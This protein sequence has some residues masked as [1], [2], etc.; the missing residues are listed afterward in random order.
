MTA[1]AIERPT[2][3][4][5]DAAAVLGIS[6]WTT[7]LQLYRRLAGEAAPAETDLE[8]L[9]EAV[10]WGNLLEPVVAERYAEVTGR[11]VRREPRRLRHKVHAMLTAHIDRR[12]DDPERI[13]EVKT[14]RYGRDWGAEGTDEVPPHYVA[15]CMHYLAVTGAKVCDLA[16]LI[17]G[18]D[19]RVYPIER[20][21]AVVSQLIERE[22]EFWDR[23]QRRDPP[24][25]LTNAEAAGR[26]LPVIGKTLV[27]SPT[28]LRD[29]DELHSVRAQIAELEQRQGML[30]LYLKTA[31][32]DAECLTD[33]AGNVHATWKGQ[34][35]RRLD[36]KAIRAAHEE[37]CEPFMR[38]TTTRVFRLTK[39]SP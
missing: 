22:L 9:S 13:L 5:S 38:E 34:S 15:Q 2:I 7:P 19:F 11:K 31:M 6:P 12:T 37:L 16:V 21:E 10:R 17:A 4:G 14:A 32:T 1:P 30:E 24:D 26:W 3:G 8:E 20:D 36:T 29:L 33:E 27:A 39:R 28:L 35:S 25:P 23:V 18:S